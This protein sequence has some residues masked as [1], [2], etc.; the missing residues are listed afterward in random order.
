MYYIASEQQLRFYT[1]AE[2]L[3]YARENGFQKVRHDNGN[4]YL[5]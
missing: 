4:E 1:L 3:K 2:A 5:V